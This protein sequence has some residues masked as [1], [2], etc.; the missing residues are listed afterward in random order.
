MTRPVVI[1]PWWFALPLFAAAV[2]LVYGGL[3]VVG[4]LV[5]YLGLVIL[6]GW[7]AFLAMEG[8]AGA[9]LRAR[10]RR[11]RRFYRERRLRK[12]GHL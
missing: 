2:A 1:I 5:G 6:L 8:A 12:R 7:L 10:D 4:L 11:E 3:L 9:A